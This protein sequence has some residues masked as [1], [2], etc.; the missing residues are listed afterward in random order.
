MLCLLC[1]APPVAAL[2]DVVDALSAAGDNKVYD[3]STSQFFVMSPVEIG[4]VLAFFKG[5]DQEVKFLHDPNMNSPPYTADSG[6][7][8]LVGAM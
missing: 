8:T 6:M 1:L 5:N 7:Q 3:W 4:E 2:C